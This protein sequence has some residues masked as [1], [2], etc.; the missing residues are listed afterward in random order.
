MRTPTMYAVC[1]NSI[2]VAYLKYLVEHC[3]W[4]LSAAWREA[5]PALYTY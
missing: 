3:G 2:Q 5:F 1:M 4:K